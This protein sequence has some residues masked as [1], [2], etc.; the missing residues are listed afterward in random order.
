MARKAG[1]IPIERIYRKKTLPHRT[2]RKGSGKERICCRLA[3]QKKSQ[4][5]FHATLWQTKPNST[6]ASSGSSF[7]SAFFTGFVVVVGSGAAMTDF[8]LGA[9]GNATAGVFDLIWDGAKA[10]AFVAEL[11]GPAIGIG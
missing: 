4:R 10:G 11:A 1:G 6:Y 9:L 7:G 2:D 5:S 8:T 3:D